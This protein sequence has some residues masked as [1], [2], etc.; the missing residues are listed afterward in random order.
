MA[1]RAFAE[2]GFNLRKE[3][4]AKLL[5]DP[6]SVGLGQRQEVLPKASA[7]DAVRSRSAEFPHVQLCRHLFARIDAREF[8]GWGDICSQRRG[9]RVALLRIP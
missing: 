1:E 9:K 6:V 8:I 2:S 7:L 4:P 5:V 3:T